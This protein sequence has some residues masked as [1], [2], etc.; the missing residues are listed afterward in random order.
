VAEAGGR[1]GV[2][3]PEPDLR[4]GRTTPGDRHRQFELDVAE[5]E[6]QPLAL[7]GGHRLGQLLA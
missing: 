7:P 5:R 2:D 6:T 1:V 4:T 3:H